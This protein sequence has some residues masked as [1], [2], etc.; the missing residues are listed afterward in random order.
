MIDTA[1]IPNPQEPLAGDV[2]EHLCQAAHAA[3]SWN[4]VHR[5][6]SV[7][8]FSKRVGAARNALK[9][10]EKELASP[11]FA[12]TATGEAHPA[13][14]NSALADL[15]ENYRLLRSAIHDVA[16][17][18]RVV[19]KL[20]R[21]LLDGSQ[22]ELPGFTSVPSMEIFLCHPFAL[23]FKSCSCTNLLLSEN[24]GA[25]PCSSSLCC[26][27]RYLPKQTFCW[28]QQKPISSPGPQPS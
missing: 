22:D 11:R 21:I 1:T 7:S 28:V 17:G 26:L 20:P 6:A 12:E 25:S 10:I 13:P 5:P 23:S 8:T 2:L 18:P 3:A 24:C 14:R 19:A 27:N 16:D 4:V 9:Q 15:R